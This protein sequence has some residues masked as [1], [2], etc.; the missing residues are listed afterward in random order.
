MTM[1]KL[2]YC[3]FPGDFGKM[4]PKKSRESGNVELFSDANGT[5]FF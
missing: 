2:K 3:Q 5:R 1:R 4:S